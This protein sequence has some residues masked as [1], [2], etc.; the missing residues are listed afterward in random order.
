MYK[1]SVFVAQFP[2]TNIVKV[3]YAFLQL[4]PVTKL[5]KFALNLNLNLNLNQN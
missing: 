1:V 4:T 5:L 2:L 3:F